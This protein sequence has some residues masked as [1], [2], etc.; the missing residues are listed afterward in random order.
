MHGETRWVTNAPAQISQLELDIFWRGD[1]VA[2]NRWRSQFIK[3]EPRA[4]EGATVEQLKDWGMVGLY[5]AI[6]GEG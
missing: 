6:G 4:T 1:A 3:G 5:R 2:Y